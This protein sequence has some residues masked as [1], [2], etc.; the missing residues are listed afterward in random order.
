MRRP[1]RGIAG[2]AR[3]PGDLAAGGG[4]EGQLVVGTSHG[5][6]CG[7]PFIVSPVP[8]EKPSTFVRTF[9]CASCPDAGWFRLHGGYIPPYQRREVIRIYES[10]N[11]T[12]EVPGSSALLTQA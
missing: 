10:L 12:L 9:E 6:A 11:G 8:A 1:S 4:G 3:S 7:G 5:I 2:G